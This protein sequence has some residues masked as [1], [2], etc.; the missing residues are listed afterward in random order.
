MSTS[1]NNIANRGKAKD[2]FYKGV[3][4]IPV[5]FVG[6]DSSY[7]AAQDEGGKMVLDVEGLPLP[8]ASIRAS[9]TAE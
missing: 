3:K 9:S 4:V 5:K 1:K 6:E 2:I 7:I 8:W